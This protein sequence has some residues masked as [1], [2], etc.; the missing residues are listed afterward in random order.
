MV[1]VFLLNYL[2]FVDKAFAIAIF[3]NDEEY[4][5]NVDIYATLFVVVEID[6]A[7]QRFPVAIECA[8]NQ[9]ALAIDDW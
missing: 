1:P 5:A 3:L 8:T 7:T 4:I 9:F 6:V 2:H